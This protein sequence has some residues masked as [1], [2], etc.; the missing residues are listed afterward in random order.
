MDDK[1]VNA[2]QARMVHLKQK[3]AETKNSINDANVR[4]MKLESEIAE[5]ENWIVMWHQL[6]GTSAKPTAAERMQ[7]SVEISKRVRPKNP[8]REVVVEYV[9]QIIQE[10]N[11]AQSR[12]DLFDELIA[13]NVIIRGKD[14]EMVL[15]TM[16]WRSRDKIV[17]IPGHGYWLK[18]KP[19]D[20][21]YYDPQNDDI[22]GVAA[23]DPEDGFEADDEDVSDGGEF[24]L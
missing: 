1:A 12:K 7:N 5:L 6:T 2:A 4:L 18:D 21:A 8:D 13:R 22:F 19:Y 11:E 10:K 20:A 23:K 24:D 14:P 15:S 17:R 9:L 3:A 16:L